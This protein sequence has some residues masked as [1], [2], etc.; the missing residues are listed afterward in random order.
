MFSPFAPERPRRLFLALWPGPGERRQ[1]AALAANAADRR[2][3]R[4]DNLHMTLVFLGA[5]D[6]EKRGVYESALAGLTVPSLEL[7]LDRYGYWPKSRILWLGSSQPPPEL[8][9]LVADLNRR[10]QGCG[11]VPENRAFQA[12]IT[13]ARNFAGPTPKFPPEP[14]VCWRIG[15]VALVESALGETGSRYRVLRGWPGG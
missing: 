13:L 9:E 5:T 6:A 10:L 8:D 14:P 1:M 11:F 2:R 15:E 3:V 12:H 4:D 7:R